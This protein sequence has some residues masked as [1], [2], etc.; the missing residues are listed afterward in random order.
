MKRNQLYNDN[1]KLTS[2]IDTMTSF[3][4]YIDTR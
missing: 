2:L 3:F 4:E 1:D